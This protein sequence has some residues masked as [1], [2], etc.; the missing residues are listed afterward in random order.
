MKVRSVTLSRTRAA[1]AR[2]IVRSRTVAVAI[3]CPVGVGHK[4]ALSTVDGDAGLAAFDREGEGEADA[5]LTEE[6]LVHDRSRATGP[7]TS[8]ASHRISPRTEEQ[9]ESQL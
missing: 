4:D 6:Q 3:T 7:Q 2:V 1:P 8:G 5:R 9:G